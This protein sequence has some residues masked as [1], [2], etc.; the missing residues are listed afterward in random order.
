MLYNDVDAATLEPGG[1]KRL[2]D[3]WGYV[4]GAVYTFYQCTGEEKYREA[5]RRVLKNLPKYRN[6]SWE[7]NTN[8]RR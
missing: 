1:N 2:S 8:C 7:P 5:V 6:Y 3:N 4:Y